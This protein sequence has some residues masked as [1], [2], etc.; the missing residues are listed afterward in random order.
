MNAQ[1]A[2]A[3]EAYVARIVAAAPPLSDAQKAKL[4]PL[5]S[6]GAR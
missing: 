3:I 1:T 6:G 2:A 5:L 4:R